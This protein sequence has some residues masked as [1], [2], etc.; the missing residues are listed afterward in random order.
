MQST[1][2]RKRTYRSRHKWLRCSFEAVVSFL[3]V[4]SLRIHEQNMLVLHI[5]HAQFHGILSWHRIASIELV[6]ISLSIRKRID[7][8]PL[9]FHTETPQVDFHLHKTE[10]IGQNPLPNLCKWHALRR[11]TVILRTGF[12]SILIDA[13]CCY[14]SVAKHFSDVPDQTLYPPEVRRKLNPTHHHYVYC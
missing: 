1:V 10:A 14:Q 4:W 12:R 7:F 6:T 5:S 11:R 8:S 9:S 13:R 3:E 2:S